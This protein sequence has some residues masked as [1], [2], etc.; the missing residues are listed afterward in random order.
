M[1]NFYFEG[2][3]VPKNQ[4]KTIQLYRQSADQGYDQAEFM[5]VT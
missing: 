3:G 4:S 5:L 2:E 1:V